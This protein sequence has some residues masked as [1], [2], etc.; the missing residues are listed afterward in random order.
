MFVSQNNLIA[1]R[2]QHAGPEGCWAGG[3]V[4][5]QGSYH[6]LEYAK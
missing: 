4:Q 1:V 5:S 2:K 3:S 6:Q